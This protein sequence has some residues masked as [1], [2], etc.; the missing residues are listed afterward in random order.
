M[1]RAHSDKRDESI[2][3]SVVQDETLWF[4]LLL[5]PVLGNYLFHWQEEQES[6]LL[7]LS[8]AWTSHGWPRTAGD[9]SVRCG[10]HVA[11]ASNLSRSQHC[12][13]I[14]TIN[15]SWCS[16][17][18]ISAC[19]V[20]WD[21]L[22]LPVK[23]VL[24]YSTVSICDYTCMK[25]SS[26][27]SLMCIWEVADCWW[28]GAV[29]NNG[30]QLK[31]CPL[32][33]ALVYGHNMQI[34][35]GRLESAMQIL[36]FLLSKGQSVQVTLTNNGVVECYVFKHNSNSVESIDQLIHMTVFCL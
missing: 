9:L 4:H 7:V 8:T 6:E 36:Q 29:Q 35:A 13:Q 21:V 33:F 22:G 16:S 10:P 20:T 14:S 18:L 1:L 32:A 17:H 23:L 11:V 2:V 26:K 34:Q 24:L 19:G 27:F 3:T 15:S 30:K 12:F 5:L 31:N 28:P 25:V